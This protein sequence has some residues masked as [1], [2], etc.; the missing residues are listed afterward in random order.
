MLV[1]RE[2]ERE[3]K[4]TINSSKKLSKCSKKE[5]QQDKIGLERLEKWTKSQQ[6]NQK[7]Y[8]TRLRQMNLRMKLAWSLKTSA[9]LIFSTLKTPQ[10]RTKNNWR[11]LATMNTVWSHVMKILNLKFLRLLHNWRLLTECPPASRT[12]LSTSKKANSRKSLWETLF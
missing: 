8:L 4:D 3:F 9:K 1:V 12:L 11:D 7:E 6:Q 5:F 10:L 2:L